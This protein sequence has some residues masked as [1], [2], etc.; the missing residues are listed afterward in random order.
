[1]TER[2]G[3][4]DVS[5]TSTEARIEDGV[6][7]LYGDKWFTSAIGSEMALALART[8]GEPG[9]SLYCLET[10]TAEGAANRIRV[11]RL[12][13]K[14]GTRAM[15]T[16][17]LTLEGTPAERVGEAGQGVRTIATMLNITRLYNACCAAASMRRALALAV[18]YARRRIAFGRRLIDH[19]LHAATLRALELELRAALVLV[20]EGAALLGAEETGEAGDEGRA[21]LRLMTPVIKLYTAKQAVAVASEALECFGGAGY[22]EDTGL[23]RLLRDAQVL[24]IWEGTTNVLSLDVLRALAKTHGFDAFCARVDSCV[25][26]SSQSALQPARNSV[27]AGLE[28]LRSIVAR[29]PDVSDEAAEVGARD[30]ACALARCYAAALLIELATAETSA[31][32]AGDHVAA[33]RQWCARELAPLGEPG[34]ARAVGTFWAPGS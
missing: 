8:P 34:A 32:D 23:P 1:M 28:R 5:T 29:L 26:R 22:I 30:L 16:A 27:L 7:R 33:A 4:S 11:H 18:D 2:T 3:G 9:L 17:E 31:Q 20:F 25:R 24:P 13:D 10:R 6:H 12:K 19:P 15:P 21:L 14:L